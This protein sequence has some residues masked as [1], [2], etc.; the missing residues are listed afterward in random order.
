MFLKIKAV[1][2]NKFNFPLKNEERIRLVKKNLNKGK[3][4]PLNKRILF[5]IPGGMKSMVN[6]EACLA[7]ALQLRGA[8]IEMV[9]CDGALSGCV[10]RDITEKTPINKWKKKCPS[11]FRNCKEVIKILGLPCKG[12]GE[13]IS[14]QQRERLLTLSQKIPSN[15]VFSF[16]YLDVEV[17]RYTLS[18]ASRYLKGK[19][20]KRQKKLIREYLFSALVAAEAA[21]NCFREKKPDRIFM[22]HGIYVDWGPAL[23]VAIE[24]KIPVTGWTAA[25]LKDR[26]YLRTTSSKKYFNLYGMSDKGWNQRKRKPLTRKEGKQKDKFFEDRYFRN[27]SFDIKK[28]YKLL[29]GKKK[30]LQKLDISEDKPIWCIFTH[31]S[32]DSAFSYAPALYKTASSWLIETIQAVKKARSVNWLLKIHPAEAWLPT[33][34]GVY[35]MIKKKF[36]NLPRHIN[37]IPSNSDINPFGLYSLLDG[38]V[39]IFGTPGLELLTQGKPVI[40]A[41]KAHYGKKGFTYD[42]K[43]KAQYRQLLRDAG[44]LSPLSPQQKK[45]AR[46]YAYSFFIQRQ[47]PMPPPI[48]T[49]RGEWWQIDFNKLEMLLPG[50]NPVL[51]MVCDKIIN[52]GDFIMEEEIVDFSHKTKKY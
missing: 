42:A 37:I 25:Y 5:W 2:N 47:I 21:T 50:K 22:S 10:S 41:G 49:K 40:L 28:N 43:T 51:N 6:V 9:V 52:G 36:P 39:T 26:F 24:N 11:C 30:I 14:K 34:R 4:I 20:I 29:T 31:I 44:K 3:I 13:F 27:K 15:R 35:V 33:A 8:E 38:G 18:S 45:M 16:K 46:Q 12:I 17:G 32:W 1:L 19:P 7:K 23:S 48:K